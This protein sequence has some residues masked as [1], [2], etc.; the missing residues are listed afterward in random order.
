VLKI[1]VFGATGGTGQATLR[2]L[3]A[4]GHQATA[5]A[6]DPA[7]RPD[8]AGV[9]AIRG[10]VMHAADVTAAVPG[11]DAVI[12]TLGNAQN[13]FALMFGARRTTPRDVCEVGTRHIISAMQQAGIRRLIVL[14]AFGIGATRDKLPLAFKIFYR[15]VLREHMVDKEKQEALVKASG[16]DWTLVQP[17]GLTDAPATGR[18]LA[19]TDGKIRGQQMSRADVAACLVSILDAGLYKG[20]TVALSG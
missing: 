12:V 18:W 8:M 15:L 2:A 10:D 20:A 13:P 17:V 7:K 14:T 6:R 3:V 11:H 1:L 16:L 9:T 19:D 4:A 5:F